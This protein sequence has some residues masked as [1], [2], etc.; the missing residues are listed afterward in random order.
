MTLDGQGLHTG[1]PARVTFAR[2]EGPLRLAFGGGV[3][4]RDQLRVASGERSTRVE[5]SGAATLGTVEHLFAALAGLGIHHGLSV[6]VEGPEVPLLDGGARA[7]V[8]ALRSLAIPQAA[9]R[10]RVARAGV[11]EVLGSRYAFEPLEGDLVEVHV[12]IDFSD[13][14]LAP[15]ASW[16]G[17]ADDFV[18]RIASART[19]GFEHE[20]Q[21][22]AAR[23]LASHVAPESV[24]VIGPERILSAG[25][26]FAADEPAR[27]KLLD[28]LGD[29][30]VHGGPPLGR[31]TAFAPGHAR[32]HRAV[33]QA[34]A[35]GVLVSA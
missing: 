21:E 5:A 6:T 31:V 35:C 11:V 9:P 17:G 16:R 18:A 10:L 26:P 32:T 29:L 13:A 2:S 22:L 24:V 20:V 3:H 4:A 23:G 28:L 12:E 33:D 14:R 8:D 25:T 27:H 7:F 30:Y 1:A 15:R 34:R 19:F